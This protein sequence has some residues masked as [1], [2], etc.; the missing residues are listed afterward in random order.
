MNR[1][2]AFLLLCAAILPASVLNA[3]VT[4]P[5]FFSDNM[6]LQQQ[7]QVALWGWADEGKRVTVKPSWTNDSYT[8]KVS[9]KGRW[10]MR[11]P[12]PQAG[13][14]Y[15]ISFEDAGK[16]KT[17]ISNVLL[18]EVWFCSGQSNMAMPMKGYTK[19]PVEGS[20]GV[21]KAAKAEIPIRICRI[22]RKASLSPE[23]ICE[24][25]WAENI[26]SEVEKTSA[27]AYF[28]AMKVQQTLNVP[29]G[30]LEA[31]WGGTPIEAWMDKETIEENFD[32]EFNLSHLEGGDAPAKP[33][34]R[35]CTIFNGMVNP[36]IPF[37]FKGILWYQ[38]EFNRKRYEQY[39]RLQPAYVAMMR[40]RFQNPD[41]PFYFVQ[42]APYSYD[43][44]EGFTVGY[45]CEAQEKTLS[46]I[47]GSGMVATVDTGEKDVIHPSRKKEVGERLAAL[48]LTKTYGLDLGTD[49][50]SP[51]L[52]KVEFD[53]DKAIVTL[54][55]ASGVRIV[56]S[57]TSGFE[58][59]GEDR[60][61][62][63]ASARLLGSDTLEIRSGQVKE[64]VAVR[65][66]FRNWCVGTVFN[67][68]GIP[69][70]PFRSDSW[71]SGR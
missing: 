41:A 24:G 17:V 7:S 48:A 27:A 52:R 36:L 43:D 62:Y 55:T 53:A 69:L 38:G 2:K 31:D 5:P 70:A 25:S 61:F 33:K 11:I 51:S 35:A 54:N 60:V 68:S 56:E 40:D 1:I 32:G 28:F 37:T 21:I 50:V 39:S 6:V 29:V 19:Q 18:G 15:S 71:E 34:L 23:D 44:P 20:A 22:K 65:Y 63:P 3:K 49:A 58:L 47:P 4:L 26:P 8:A 13:G 30:I 16:E 42:I 67:A 14:P 64:P 45:F 66:C 57:E 10:E 12:T 9:R 46:V 59:A